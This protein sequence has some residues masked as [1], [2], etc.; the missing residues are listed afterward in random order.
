MSRLHLIIGFLFW[1]G[2]AFSQAEIQK[3]VK[4]GD[5][6]M[7]KGD[8]YYALDYYKKASSIDSNSVELIWKLAETYR[9]Y[10][11]YFNAEEHYQKV[12]D[13]EEA[14]IYPESI[15]YLALMQKQNGKYDVALESFKTAKRKY[16][17]DKKKY[18][19]Q[20]SKREIESCLY[21]LNYLADAQLQIN[22]LPDFINS[23]DAEFGH[24]IFG[25]QLIFSS[26]KGD[27]ISENEEVYSKA[28]RTRLYQTDLSNEDG[29]VELIE[30]LF[31]EK[32]NTGNGT[33]SLDGKRFYFSLCEDGSTSYRCKIMVAQFEEDR[34]SNIDS[35]GSII[36]EPD[37][38]NTMPHIAKVGNEEWLFF[39]SDRNGGEGGLD[40]YYS[41]I[42][43]GNQFSKCYNIKQL[44]SPDNETSP[45][46]FDAE[47][48]LYFSSS[49]YDGF[50][51]LDIF[52][53]KFD[54]DFGEPENIGLPYNSPA[55]DLYY[56]KKNDLSYLS[57]N[58]IGVNYSKNPTC[59]NDI[60]TV[61]SLPTPKPLEPLVI[62]ETLEDLNRRLPV[63]LYFHNDEPNPKSRD[64]VTKVNYINSYTTYREML[65]KY[66]KE[67]SS[68]LSGQQADEAKED[69]ESFFIEYIDQ[70]VKD[71]NQFR[72]L[73][74]IELQK[75]LDINL[76]VKGFASPLAKS[77][78]NVNL[79]K[80]RI[81]S[82]ENY[83][84]EYENDVFR[85]YIEQ[86][87][88]DGGSLTFSQV[89][90][91]EYVANN[92][93]SDNFNDQ[94]NSVYSRAA[95]LERKIE[96]QSVTLVQDS[97]ID[98]TLESKDL[99]K[100]LGSITSNKLVAVTYQLKN[101]NNHAID[102]LP[103]RV[104]CDCSQAEMNKT[105]LEPG[106]ISTI[107]FTFNPEGYKGNVV[108]SI[109][110]RTKN[111]TEEMRLILTA[112]VMP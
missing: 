47:Q 37:C 98:L 18:L 101:T 74:L 61:K 65:N 89:P 95:A 16:T 15:L 48:T 110:V 103:I 84:L 55:N 54:E 21:A 46:W 58:R 75:G 32:M 2:I 33:F 78:Y 85:P 88:T 28:Y 71:L 8:Y 69:I 60:F 9:A 49:W 13:K 86:N 66:Q 112:E 70:G 105:H 24:T 52:S 79:T 104:P 67:Y 80:R 96:I 91:G 3:Y 107:S 68:D 35:L 51:G 87:S 1:A 25:D 31:F 56:F 111:G 50:G 6:L 10:K 5:D 59:C 40:L 81:S 102:F 14:L 77:D 19:Y 23:K 109:Y 38:N 83:L 53:S 30:D 108:K 4:Y 11:D 44:N 39:T 92:L 45:F 97:L 36:N 27:S 20:K 106:E 100:N 57:S 41:K 90:F 63:T 29:K 76:T 26:L 17:R 62:E 12:Y 7:A 64:T 82:L 93:V 73:L 99:I 43:N 94:K 42:K 22:K 34:W 72:N